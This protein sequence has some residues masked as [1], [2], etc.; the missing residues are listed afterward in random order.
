MNILFLDLTSVP[1]LVG[2]IVLALAFARR[3]WRLIG[4]L[5]FLFFIVQLIFPILYAW[6]EYYYV[7][8]GFTL[9]VAFG[10]AICGAFESRMPRWVAWAV[11]LA[12][13]GL[14]GAGF[15]RDF[16]PNQ[17]QISPGG[18]NLTLAL[19]SFMAPDEVMV[20]AGDDW[21][22]MT[23]YFA[24]RRAL[25]IRRDLEQTWTE[26]IPAFDRLKGED[27][28][29]LVLHGD[30]AKN[31]LLI[32]LAVDHFHL[33]PRPAFRWRDATV[34]VHEQVR[35]YLA[36]LLKNVPEIEL[37]DHS[38]EL[39]P[40][41]RHEIETAGLLRRFRENFDQIQPEPF[42]FYTTYGVSH[43][44]YEGRQ[45]YNAHPDTRLWFR[46]PGGQHTFSAEVGIVPG[47]YDPAVPYGD[48][49]DGVEVRLERITAK[50]EKELIFSRLIDP[51]GSAS[52]RGLLPIEHTFSLP[53]ESVVLLS[54]APGPHGN[55]ARDWTM[56]GTVK[57]R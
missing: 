12:I 43:F 34:Y 42:R 2:C 21:S 46:L 44:E 10:L 11:V 14:Q 47:A 51:R 49:T 28:T 4:V 5:V 13:Y 53:G 37:L 20:V 36:E 52:D 15:V 41:L 22:S 8:S 39:N 29:A 30:Q 57:F 40:M 1:A 38:V 26:I 50:G 7:A 18:S 16:Y 9:L 56:L 3:W 35:P 55:Y 19:R 6:H 48:R 24:Q 17:R 27:V 32:Q 23:P 33:D 54:I 31:R 45:V 25:M